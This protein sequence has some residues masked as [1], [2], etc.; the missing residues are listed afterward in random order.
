MK[1]IWNDVALVICIG[2]YFFIGFMTKYVYHSLETLTE[3]AEYVE[4]N[5]VARARLDIKYYIL[6]VN[7]VVSGFLLGTY[8]TCRKYR[9]R[10]IY[11]MLNFNCLTMSICYMFIWNFV[12]DLPI[13]LAVV[14]K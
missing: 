12:N 14:L 11:T 2:I 3:S 10:S 7:V 6:V 9:L 1:I 13:F 8:L 4:A 5:P